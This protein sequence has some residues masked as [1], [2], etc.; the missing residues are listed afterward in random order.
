MGEGTPQ[1]E[2]LKSPPKLGLKTATICCSL[3]K[4]VSLH[5][6]AFTNSF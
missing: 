5:E 6:N 2:P 4:I 1:N 3:V